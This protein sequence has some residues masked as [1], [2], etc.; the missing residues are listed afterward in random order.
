[1]FFCS[2]VRLF[3]AFKGGVAVRL[4]PFF[5]FIVGRVRVK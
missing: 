2:A 3:V 5:L 1:M 4:R